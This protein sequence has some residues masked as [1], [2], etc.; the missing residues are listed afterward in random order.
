[1]RRRAVARDD[2]FPEHLA[3]YDWR[4][5]RP[6]P[7]PDDPAPWYSAWYLGLVDWRIARNAWAVERGV[8]ERLL[9]ESVGRPTPDLLGPVFVAAEQ[10]QPQPTNRVT[11]RAVRGRRIPTHG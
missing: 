2:S 1:M 7:E 4:D 11:G 10:P 6:E 9:P 5:W 3:R 8:A